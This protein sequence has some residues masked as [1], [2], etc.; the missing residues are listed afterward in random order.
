MQMEATM[1][2]Q[3]RDDP[4][5]DTSQSGTPADMKERHEPPRT[6]T[7]GWFTA[8]MYG[9]AGSGGAEFEQ[10]PEHHPEAKAAGG[11]D[12]VGPEP[13]QLDAEAQIRLRAYQFSL[14][15][16]EHPGDAV[17]DWLDAE[18]EFFDREGRNA[19]PQTR[20]GQQ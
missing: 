1:K 15:R 18:R 5:S 12:G 9:S 10:V 11:A 6:T 2:D 19:D 4:E 8:P 7:W 13:D 3:T 14:S 16:A 20:R 17:Q